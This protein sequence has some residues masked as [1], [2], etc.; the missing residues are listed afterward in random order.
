MRASASRRG[1]F[2]GTE[3]PRHPHRVEE[4]DA[5][6]AHERTEHVKDEE[7][8][9]N[10][11]GGPVIPRDIDAVNGGRSPRPG[12][13]PVEGVSSTLAAGYRRARAEEGS[14][15]LFTRLVSNRLGSLVAAVGISFG[16]HPSVIS[17][18]NLLLTTVTSVFVITRAGQADN[19]WAPG[20]TAF[21]L[22]QLGYV[23]D[24][25]DGQV[26]RATGRQSD[27]GARVDVL[28]DYA[29]QISIICAI[30]AV[31]DRFS[32]PHPILV[33][34]ISTSWFVSMII[35]LLGRA[36]GNVGHSFSERGSGLIAV[37]KLVRDYGF[38]L[39][40]SSGWL[41][42][43]PGSV[44]VPVVGLVVVNAV[45]LLASVGR[46]AWLSMRRT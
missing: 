18:T 41:A 16:V 21:I 11:H 22:W 31:L 29:A 35:F 45:F 4:K 39:F 32:D 14:G 13:P 15:G 38:V 42:V 37:I 17:L 9:V 33:A 44:V 20:V 19:W 2:D 26:A 10:Q 30:V 6:L 28:V 40:I 24:C 34:F 25:A 46:E 8:A 7:S 1:R 27:F 23:L 12:A 43:A 36:D 5:L 3:P